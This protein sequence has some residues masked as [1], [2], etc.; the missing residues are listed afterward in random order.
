MFDQPPPDR[1]AE[2]GTKY[3]DQVHINTLTAMWYAPMNVNIPPFN[4]L[5]ARQAVNYAIDRNALVKLFGGKV[6][7][8]PACQVLPPGFPG[9]ERLLPLYQEPGHQMECA[10]PGQGQAAGEGIRHRGAEGDD[11]RPRTDGRSQPSA[12]ICRAC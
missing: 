6:L 12:P 2:I 3:K 7:A 11:H 4:N 9:Y 8:Q 10:G 5:K 1:L